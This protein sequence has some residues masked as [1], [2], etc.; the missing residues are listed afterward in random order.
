MFTEDPLTRL[1]SC[2]GVAFAMGVESWD[3]MQTCP[4]ACNVKCI[5]CPTSEVGMQLRFLSCAAERIYKRERQ[6][7]AL[8]SRCRHGSHE[9]KDL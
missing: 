3:H 5:G 8:E 1:V 7:F 9:K 6:L 4:T 2:H